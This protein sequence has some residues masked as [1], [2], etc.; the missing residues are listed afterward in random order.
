[1][2]GRHRDRHQRQGLDLRDARGD[3]AQRRLSRRPLHVAAP[4]ALQRARAHRRRRDATT[5]RCVA[6]FDAVEDARPLAALPLTYFEFG[7]LAA[8]LAVRAR[9]ARRGDPR[10]RAGRPARRGQHRRCR[11][12][13]RDQRRSRSHGLSR[14]D[15]RRRSAA[16]RPASFAPGARRCAASPHPPRALLD[17]ARDIGAPLL[18]I[19]ATSASSRRHAVALLRSRRRALRP[20]DSGAARRAISSAMRR[21]RSPRSICCATRCPWQRG[22]IREGLVAVEL[23]GRFQVLPGRPTIVLDVAHNPHAARVL[24]AALGAMG[25]HPRD[26]SRSSACSPTRTSTAWSTRCSARDRSL[27]R[28]AAARTARRR[29]ADASSRRLRA[30]GVAATAIRAFD[31]D[32]DR[33]RG[34]ARGAAG[35]A[36]RIVVFGSFLTVA[37]ALA[38]IASPATRRLLLRMAEPPDINVDELR[39]RARR[40][41]VGAIVLALGGRGRRADA[42]RKR[43]EAARRGRVGARFRRSTT[44]SSSIA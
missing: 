10:G 26:A 35:E 40:R 43:P 5:P 6:A 8:L 27:V 20:A 7:T 4:A 34:A 21:P 44:A 30:A 14:P 15:A 23:P 25:F 1:M 3:A 31:D 9:E 19:G 42:A 33:M 36:D 16:R 2:P 32:R 24:A 37:A 17:H 12:R 28:R 22:A 13:G 18:R 38:R 39:R 41:L 29:R 11:R